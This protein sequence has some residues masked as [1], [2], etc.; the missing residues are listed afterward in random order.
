MNKSNGV[1][2]RQYMLA[3]S[4]C[5]IS[6][7]VLAFF[8]GSSKG[9]EEA[10][11]FIV[12]LTEIEKQ[13]ETE[14]TT[15]HA[16]AENFANEDIFGWDNVMDATDE[17]KEETDEVIT[18]NS[19][20]ANEEPVIEV[21][22]PAVETVNKPISLNFTESDKL[23]WPVNGN[24]I[25]NYSMD[26]S[27]YFSTLKQYRYNPALIIASEEDTQVLASAKGQVIHMEEQEDIGMTVTLDLGNEY[28]LV[29]GQLKEVCVHA[30]EVVE[31]GQVIGLV[32]APSKSYVVEGSNL[33][34]KLTRNGQPVNPMEYLK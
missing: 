16:K 30:G 2:A 6:V 4:I 12:D 24:V 13:E 5:A 33:Y 25:M 28:Q 9:K 1:V 15:K 14:V 17:V 8:Y 27:I 18:D 3:L 26:K 20:Q 34:M 22:P 19:N 31:E 23:L 32:A 7:S 21:D 11:E 29:Y 10:D